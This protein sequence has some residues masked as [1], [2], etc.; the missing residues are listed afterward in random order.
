[1]L[2]SKGLIDEGEGGGQLKI[3]RWK[4]SMTGS[5]AAMESWGGMQGSGGGGRGSVLEL[6]GGAKKGFSHR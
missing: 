5:P 3:E 2:I 6:K 4:E 1:M